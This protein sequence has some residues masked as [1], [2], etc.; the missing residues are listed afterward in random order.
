M[1]NAVE[2]LVDR[3]PVR[4]MLGRSKI[5]HAMDKKECSAAY[6]A[7]LQAFGIQQHI[8]NAFE[9]KRSVRDHQWQHHSYR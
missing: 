9:A 5:R 3:M 2:G 4:E 7:G 8:Q 6:I 1:V